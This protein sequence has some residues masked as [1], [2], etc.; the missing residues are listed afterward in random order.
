MDHLIAHYGY[1]VVALL[2]AAE[3]VGIPLP[4][5][6]ALITA[7]ALSASGRLSLPWVVTAA[8]VG[9][10]IGGCG[11]YWIGKTGGTVVVTR[12]GKWV[13]IRAQELQRAR[14]F[15]ARH[16]AAAVVIGRFLPVIRILNGLV[17]GITG[18]P[19]R[20]FAVVN[21]V[22]GVLWSV[23]FGVLGFEFSRNIERF[24]RHY[25]RPV[26]IALI[27]V[28]V[29]AFGLYKWH[30]RRSARTEARLRKA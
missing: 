24:Q 27:A 7:A 15:F 13:G 3:G 21:A 18:M 10:A 26:V 25:G 19:F 14:E 6:T 28:G 17:A 9:V 23:I 22:A 30:E 1:A 29:T 2:V 4:G 8:A 20:R 11:G 5:E 16:G 12:Y